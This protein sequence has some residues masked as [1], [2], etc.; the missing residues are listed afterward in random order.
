MHQDGI[1]YKS[2]L[3][4][5]LWNP[6]CLGISC[7]PCATPGT[8]WSLA[9][10]WWHRSPSDEATARSKLELPSVD[11]RSCWKW[12]RMEQ[13]DQEDIFGSWKETISVRKENRS[14]H[15]ANKSST[16]IL[17]PKEHSREGQRRLRKL[18]WGASSPAET[19]ILQSWTQSAQDAQVCC[20]NPHI[21]MKRQSSKAL[22]SQQTEIDMCAVWASCWLVDKWQYMAIALGGAKIC[23]VS[24]QKIKCGVFSRLIF[25]QWHTLTHTHNFLAWRKLTIFCLLSIHIMAM[26]GHFISAGAHLL[27]NVLPVWFLMND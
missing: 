8:P 18:Q 5:D 15:W 23:A 19:L 3:K 22:Q 13:V 21:Q 26:H 7:H 2:E 27:S 1:P 6:W 9:V 14:P 25:F 12:N 16:A 17:D 20:A 24:V 11:Q 10:M 4:L